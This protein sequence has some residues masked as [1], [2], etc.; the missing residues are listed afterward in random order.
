MLLFE[1]ENLHVEIDGKKIL[2]APIAL[3]AASARWLDLG[4]KA[5]EI[6]T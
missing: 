3:R 6:S 5:A 4:P 2:R 1:I